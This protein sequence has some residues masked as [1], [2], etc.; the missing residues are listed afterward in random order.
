MRF[1]DSINFIGTIFLELKLFFS[2]D[3]LLPKF[4]KIFSLETHSV[5]KC[6]YVGL[7]RISTIPEVLRFCT[8]GSTIDFIQEIS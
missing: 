6:K 5:K 1:L 8:R 2:P 4:P 7:V 3:F